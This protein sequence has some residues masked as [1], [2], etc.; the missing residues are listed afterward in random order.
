MVVALPADERP[1]VPK[2]DALIVLAVHSYI[3]SQANPGPSSLRQFYRS[4]RG[5]TCRL[6]SRCLSPTLKRP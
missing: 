2:K 4:W 1:P 3:P 6:L 5:A